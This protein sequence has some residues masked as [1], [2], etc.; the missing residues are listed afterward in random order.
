MKK[1]K[2]ITAYDSDFEKF[3]ELCARTIRFYAAVHGYNFEIFKEEEFFGRHPQWAKIGLI[4]A[5]LN[6]N[7][8]EWILW[9]DADAFFITAEKDILSETN[10]NDLN[11]VNHQALTDIPIGSLPGVKLTVER[12]NTG[13]MLI[14]NSDWSKDFFDNAWNCDFSQKH[15]WRDNAA[16]MRALGYF[17]EISG[18]NVPNNFNNENLKKTNWLNASWNAVPTQKHDGSSALALP[19]KPI[20]VHL[21]G[22]PDIKRIEFLKTLAFDNLNIFRI[23]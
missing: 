4:N 13:V 12:P 10:L 1:L 17:Y 18:Y 7:E 19:W 16:V 9:V 23:K 6:K 21:A 14:K 5:E 22:M 15:E 8:F 20:I 3:G 11:L 2:I